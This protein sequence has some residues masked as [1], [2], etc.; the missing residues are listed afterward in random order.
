MK[1]SRHLVS[2]LL[3]MIFFVSLYILINGTFSIA[4]WANTKL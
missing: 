2:N 1:D 4:F 3:L